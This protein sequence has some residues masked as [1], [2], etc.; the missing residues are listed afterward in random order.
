MKTLLEQ[1]QLAELAVSLGAPDAAAIK[2]EALAALAAYRAELAKPAPPVVHAI[3][4]ST[5]AVEYRD[6]TGKV[7]ELAVAEVVP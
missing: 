6:A 5:G 2:A 1:L 4:T 3:V 7:A